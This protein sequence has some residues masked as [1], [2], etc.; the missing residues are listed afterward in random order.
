[1]F[2]FRPKTG[3]VVTWLSILHF[4]SF[5][6]TARHSQRTIKQGL[7]V[8]P[9]RCPVLQSVLPSHKV[10]GRK[11]N[12]KTSSALQEETKSKVEAP[13]YTCLV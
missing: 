2:T 12:W 1:M 5:P 6:E 3:L 11:A 13:S 10:V 8:S 7:S 4:L 9:S